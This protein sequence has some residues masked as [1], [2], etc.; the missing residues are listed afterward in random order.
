MDY[1]DYTKE[2]IKDFD[3]KDD[4][5]LCDNYTITLAEGDGWVARL[6]PC[7]EIRGI[8]TT[9]SGE[10]DIYNSNIN[11]FFETNEDLNKAESDGKLILNN[12][13]WFD[14]EFI[15][16]GQYLDIVSDDSVVFSVRE[17]VDTFKDYMADPDFIKELNEKVE[18]HRE[19]INTI[20]QIFEPLATWIINNLDVQTEEDMPLMFRQPYQDV[21][22]E[23]VMERIKK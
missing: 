14:L 20:K 2:A 18:E 22:T 10:E 12:N 11:E 23:I 3:G 17:G 7:G 8:L 4:S 13:N 19:H 15:A 9:E 5:L 21:L 16:E 1:K 6:Q